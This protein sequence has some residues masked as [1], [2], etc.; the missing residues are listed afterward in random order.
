MPQSSGIQYVGLFICLYDGLLVYLSGISSSLHTT[1][2]LNNA[3]HMN[4]R[5]SLPVW[6]KVPQKCGAF[7]KWKSGTTVW[8]WIPQKFGIQCVGLLACLYVGLLVYWY[9]ISS[10][11]HKTLWLVNAGNMNKRSSLL[12]WVKVPQK[13]GAFKKCKTGN[14]VWY[15]IPQQFGAK[16][17]C[18]TLHYICYQNHKLST[19]KKDINLK[20]WFLRS[21][22]MFYVRYHKSEMLRI[23]RQFQRD[24]KR[25]FL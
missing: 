16:Y 1:L 5:S 23:S 3:D 7:K 13:C 8:Y 17:V 20:L 24:G 22:N 6:L 18:P 11:L 14:T 2:W 9:G 15:W 10:C 25:V 12:V 4:R 21:L 19:N